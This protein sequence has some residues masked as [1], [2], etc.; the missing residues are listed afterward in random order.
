MYD[1]FMHRDSPSAIFIRWLLRQ[2]EKEGLSNT[3]F[4]EKLGISRG[5]WGNLMEGLN[6][7]ESSPKREVGLKL[8]SAVATVYRWK[9]VVPIMTFLMDNARLAGLRKRTNKTDEKAA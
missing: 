5:S 9:A 4:A 6:H 8:L 2:R 1:K 7:E 3:Q